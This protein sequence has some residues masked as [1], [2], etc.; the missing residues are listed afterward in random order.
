MRGAHELPTG[1]PR[2]DHFWT[3][4]LTAAAS[5]RP[6]HFLIRL[7]WSHYIFSEPPATEMSRTGSGALHFHFELPAGSPRPARA[8]AASPVTSS[9]DLW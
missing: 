9:R 3:G 8:A 6:P 4:F 2:A 1:C 7:N 5:F